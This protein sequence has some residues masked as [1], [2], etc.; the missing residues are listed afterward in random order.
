MVTNDGDGY[1]IHTGVFTCE[2]PGVYSFTFFI[3]ER[4]HTEVRAQLI[5]NGVNIVD[6]ISEPLRDAHDMQGGNAAIVRLENGDAVWVNIVSAGTHV[7]GD[8]TYRFTTFT[9]FY[10]YP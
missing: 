9:G 4:S 3:G 10:L 5:V 1:N 7:E 2:E 8:S 6:A